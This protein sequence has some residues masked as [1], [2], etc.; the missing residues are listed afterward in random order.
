MIEKQYCVPLSYC[1]GNLRIERLLVQVKRLTRIA[2]LD[3]TAAVQFLKTND[4]AS[5]TLFPV[6]YSSTRRE[7]LPLTNW[8]DAQARERAHACQF[9][10]HAREYRL[11][12][13]AILFASLV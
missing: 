2:V 6:S 9:Q 12:F 4:V 11:K 5:I 10:L 7:K 8:N 3:N 1:E 13:Q